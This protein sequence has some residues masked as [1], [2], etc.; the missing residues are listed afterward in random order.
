ML[1]DL[2]IIESRVDWLTVSAKSPERLHGIAG[3]AAQGLLNEQMRGERLR[4]FHSLGWDT[5]RAGMWTLAQNEK[6]GYVSV[7]GED[8]E[9]WSRS[10][11]MLANHCSRI[12][13]CTTIQFP[14]GLDNPIPAIMKDLNEAY[15]ED[16]LADN[17]QRYS[18]L[19]KDRGITIGRRTSPFF[20][21]IYDKTLQSRGLYPRSCWRFEI[22]LK[23]H[24]SEHEHSLY[25]VEPKRLDLA[26]RIVRDHFR[27]WNVDVPGIHGPTIRL[28]KQLRKPSDADRA[29]AWL[30]RQVR[31]TVE[32]L[33]EIGRGE[34]VKRALFENL[35]I[36]QEV[37]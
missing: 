33:F 25:L 23:R 6:G 14:T 1:T 28:A 10:L 13:Y 31:P 3:I 30:A 24:A 15:G 12:D 29:L 7:G 19:K 5:A 2:T 34:D 9:R 22:E 17:I 16:R 8:A 36:A 18:G 4:T 35:A 26:G 11:L 27:H 32:W 37:A 21:R 20:G